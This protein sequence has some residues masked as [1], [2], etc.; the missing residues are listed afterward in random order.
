MSNE[1]YIIQK[2][3]NDND[4]IRSFRTDLIPESELLNSINSILNHILSIEHGG[5]VEP[6]WIGHYITGFDLRFLWKRFIVNR[7]KPAVRIPYDA[8]PWEMKYL[9]LV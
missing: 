7:I 8:K 6:I 1:R 9:I 4:V 5:V 3:I 2:E